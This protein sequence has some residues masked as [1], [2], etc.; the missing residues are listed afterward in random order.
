MRTK[1]IHRTAGP[2]TPLAAMRSPRPWHD[3][4]GPGPRQDHPPV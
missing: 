4:A 1:G 2:G 3:A